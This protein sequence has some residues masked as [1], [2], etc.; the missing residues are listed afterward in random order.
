MVWS[1]PHLTLG[2]DRDVS[3]VVGPPRNTPH[4]SW[5]C[6]QL[7]SSW[8]GKFFDTAYCIRNESHKQSQASRDHGHRIFDTHLR[9]VSKAEVRPAT[10]VDKQTTSSR[11]EQ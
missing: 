2:I 7:P 9:A 4:H 8:L 3:S 11:E 10:D 5:R 1:P 6:P